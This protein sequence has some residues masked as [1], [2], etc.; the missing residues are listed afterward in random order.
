MKP[1]LPQR[2]VCEFIA[3]FV[4][5]FIGCGAMVVDDVHGGVVSHA[6]IAIAWGLAVMTMIYAVGD[7]SGAHLN[8]AVSVAFSVAG[9]QRWRDT[10]VYSVAQVLGAVA[11]AGV[12]RLCFPEHP[13]LGS[14][15]VSDGLL[16]AG[17]FEAVMS[18][19]LMFVILGV[20]TGAKEKGITAGLAVG[21][22][23]MMDAMM[24]GPVSTASMNPARSLGP[25]L[26]SGTLD[27]AWLY[28]LI[29]TL[30]AAGAVPVYLYIRCG[31]RGMRDGACCVEHDPI[32]D[33]PAES[34]PG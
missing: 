14:T 31:Q 33:T 27:H 19:I 11:A 34:V 6:G 21:G 7:I 13:T 9:R 29:P 25:M 15:V 22:V 3:T 1:T 30:A 24:G 23:V 18:F 32:E 17:V 16:A 20:S 2:G 5:V 10:G 26:V 4:L 8:P 12:L 28:V